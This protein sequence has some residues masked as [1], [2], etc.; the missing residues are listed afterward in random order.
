MPVVHHPDPNDP[1]HPHR[2]PTILIRP[3][4]KTPS[5]KSQTDAECASKKELDNV[6][7]DQGVGPRRPRERKVSRI[8]QDDLTGIR[9]HFHILTYAEDGF[10]PL[11]IHARR[12][13]VDRDQ[14]RAF[15]KAV[16]DRAD[17]GSLHPLAP[18]SAV[19]RYLVRDSDDVGA[20][21][22]SIG[23]FLRANRETIKARYLVFDFRTPSVPAFAIKALTAAMQLTGDSG[24]DEV[25]ILEM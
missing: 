5:P 14:V 3:R 12:F 8:K 22:A 24:L 19:P 18:I 21:A 6:A 10:S 13:G 9:G 20:L 11:D 15:A 23:T 2:V 25:L 17:V 7:A 4:H 16:N 1:T